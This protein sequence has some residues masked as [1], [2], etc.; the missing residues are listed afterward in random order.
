MI[1]LRGLIRAGRVDLLATE[2]LGYKLLPM[3]IRLLR[4]EVYC[5]RNRVDGLVLAP[6]GFGKSTICTV[7]FA[8]FLI[9]LDPDIRI[10]ITSSTA[11]KAE[12]FL[13][14]AKEH[15]EH[16][17]RLA[18]IFGSQ[19]DPAAWRNCEIRVVDRKRFAK[20]LTL[21]A[22]GWSGAVVSKHY[23]VHLCDDLV[24][25]DNARTKGQREKLKDWYYMSLDPTL[26]P[27]GFR[28]KIGTR[29][30]PDDLYGHFLDQIAG[31]FDDGEPRGTGEAP[32][33]R[34]MACL[35]LK[36]IQDDGKSLWEEKFPLELLLEK[37]RNMGS[38]RFGAQFQN[39]TQLMKGK[40]FK[41]HWLHYY[42]RSAI[43]VRPMKIFQGVDL[44]VSKDDSADYF[45]HV[46]KAYDILSNKAYTL[47]L[48]KGRY[49]FRQQMMIILWKAGKTHDE[50]KALL[51]IPD[52]ALEQLMELFRGQGRYARR[53]W[54]RVLR[55]G[56]ESTAY[57]TVLPDTLIELVADV[58]FLRV[59]QTVDKETRMQIYSAR[60]ENGMEYL[61][62]DN[63]CDSLVDEMLLFPEAEHDDCLDAHEICNRVAA[64][65]IDMEGR[66][67]KV[68]A[69]V[70]GGA[71]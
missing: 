65:K 25:E 64:M 58:P 55:I 62:D 9:L 54:R 28:M 56:I 63:A 41:G 11:D 51:G 19:H 67:G 47:D 4:F 60:F 44:A 30:H 35:I 42:L 5:W 29:Y 3:H 33:A 18:A 50:I 13:R 38:V 68:E 71:S 16:N 40:I 59:N 49:S 36:A 2:V 31:K 26:E 17:E 53:Q 10:L 43:D 32:K 24:N 22:H 69:R 46:T 8:I 52:L 14:E 27:E 45:A 21:S 1:R 70:I 12:S 66:G 6:R 7:T 57:Q 23:D 37:K 34:K 15:F 48:V 20:E 61:P 39:E